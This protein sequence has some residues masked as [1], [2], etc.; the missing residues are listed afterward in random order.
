MSAEHDGVLSEIRAKKEGYKSFDGPSLGDKNSVQDLFT[1]IFNWF[2]CRRRSKSDASSEEEKE[3]DSPVRTL[4]TLEGVVAPVA[5]NMF[6]VLLFIRIGFVVGQAGILESVLQLVLAYFILVMTVLSINAISTNGAVE[7]G[8][9]YYMIS[10]AL[11]PEFGGSIGFI[12]F[13]ANLLAVSLSV[14]GLVE[15]M[16]ENFGPDGSSIDHPFL[17]GDHDF[18]YKYLYCTI[19]LIVC[20][21]ICIVGA[22]MFAKTSLFIFLIVVICLL[23]V[24]VSVFAKSSTIPIE[25]AQQAQYI[26]GKINSSQYCHGVN[27]SGFVQE[28]ANYTG[29]RTA[30]FRQNMFSHYQRDYSSMNMMTFTSVFSILFCCV[31][32]IL[33]GANMSGELKNPSKAIPQGTLGALML[34]FTTYFIEII[35][36][37]GSCDRCLLLNNYV[38]LQEINLWKPFVLIGIFTA[39]LSAAL[40]NL[41]GASR[42][43]QALANDRLFWFVLN[44]ATITTKSG[45]PYV[46]VLISWF[47]IQL[48]LLVGSLN[49]IAP[50]TSVFFLMSYASVNLACLALELAAAPNFRP[51][52]KYFSWHTCTLGLIGCIVMCFLISAIYTSVAII[53]MLVLT[54]ILYFRSLPAQWGSISQ[55]LIFH[56]VRKYLL[57]LDSRKDHVKYWRLQILLMVSNPRQCSELIHFI[58]DIKKGGLFVIGHV[59]LGSLD[60]Y[61]EDPILDENPKWMG[62]IDHLKVKAFVEVTLANT[63]SEGLQHLLRLSGMGGMKPNTVCLGFLDD[64]KPKDMLSIKRTGRKRSFFTRLDYK[65]ENI[66][67][68]FMNIRD[69]A[70]PRHLTSLEYVKLISDS[71]KMQ[72]NVCL[73]R[74]FDQFSKQCIVQSKTQLFIDVWPMNIFRPDSA[75]FFENAC[76]FMLQLA[77]ILTMVPDWKSKTSL[78]VFLCLNSQTDNAFQMQKKLDFFLQQ[79]RIQASVKIVTLDLLVHYMPVMSVNNSN[80]SLKSMEKFSPVPEEFIRAIN[81]IIISYSSTTAVSFLYL[82][83]PPLDTG[84]YETYLNSLEMLSENLPPTLF[85]H[86][87]HP[88]TS[89]TL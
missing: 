65:K 2:L 21:G 45:N 81:Q 38:F 47:L 69:E 78:R 56:Q 43:L 74:H 40:G 55:A 58:N 76:L 34:T 19:V 86:G 11:G 8:G 5:L 87:L 72:K 66:E 22:D 14:F 9:A 59:K 18:W 88:V 42:I 1:G 32:G 71:L 25:Y 13:V 6:S 57:M 29:L 15:A 53:V 52:F 85:V 68:L 64:A 61:S 41:I 16:I 24:F 27:A 49:A 39:T 73:C 63:V 20:L 23:S 60:S 7:G 31:T 33:T 35:L 84:D 50:A 83:I 30:T 12:F 3:E 77:C 70:D 17:K 48:V 75:T 82:P 28:S 67:N 4:R 37:G 54:I 10:R 79:L 46:A 26:H 51:T 36:V 44:P 89:T 62:L 80:G